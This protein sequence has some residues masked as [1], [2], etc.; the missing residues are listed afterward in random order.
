M[1]WVNHIA[2]GGSIM[3]VI[4]AEL[5]PITI[6]G[7]TAPDWMEKVGNALGRRI[8]HRTVTHYVAS[9]TALLAFSVFFWD[10]HHIIAAFAS[11][12]LSHVLCDALTVSGVPMGWWSDR[13]FHLF[14]GQLKTGQIG[15]YLVAGTVV[16]A[17]GFAMYMVR[18][19]TSAYMPFF[20]DWGDYYHRGL[21]DGYEWKLNRFRFF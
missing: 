12:G 14:N 18:A 19:H 1:K 10:Y 6:L 8:K 17:S 3:A 21:I 13:R 9:W 5:V 11:G 15:E 2:I 4:H 20:F 7:A 16:I